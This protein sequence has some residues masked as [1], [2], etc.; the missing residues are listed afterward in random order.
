MPCPP[1]LVRAT[2]SHSPRP[3]FSF[4][5]EGPDK[6]GPCPPRRPIDRLT[7]ATVGGYVSSTFES[8]K[9]VDRTNLR[10][11]CQSPASGRLRKNGQ[12]RGQPQAAREQHQLKADSAGME[13]PVRAAGIVKH[14]S[15]NF[16]ISAFVSSFPAE[17]FA[18]IAAISGTFAL[19]ER[20]G[21]RIRAHDSRGSSNVAL[22]WRRRAP[23]NNDRVAHVALERSSRAVVVCSGGDS[24][25][26][27]SLSAS[28]SSAVRSVHPRPPTSLL[29]ARRAPPPSHSRSPCPKAP[30][31]QNFH[32]LNF[33]FDCFQVGLTEN[34][35]MNPATAFHAQVVRRDA[36]SLSEAVSDLASWIEEIKNHNQSAARGSCKELRRRGNE[37]FAEGRFDDAVRCYTRC[38]KNANENEE[39]LPNEVLLAYSNRAMANLKLKRWKAA[40]ADATSA[41]EID[42]SHS[43]SLQRRATAR[44]SLG[45]LRAATVDVCSARDC[46]SGS[47]VGGQ[48]E[49]EERAPENASER[50]RQEL[51]RLSS[52]IDS[53]LAKAIRDAPRR[54]IAV[55]TIIS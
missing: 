14:D 51:E 52:R 54:K 18:R 30:L 29:F 35:R 3:L 1:P 16:L 25:T 17:T 41:L 24:S 6:L 43:K 44:L 13:V 42:P 39:L 5:G 2:C 33:D 12:N 26:S 21:G 34:P 49:P 7:S 19:P 31:T 11:R 10:G 36:D 23:V 55:R 32:F 15:R 28:P 9:T 50:E 37:K 40:E 53:A 22:C 46:A 4:C 27:R 20:G 47:F 48:G 45:K 8:K 38:L